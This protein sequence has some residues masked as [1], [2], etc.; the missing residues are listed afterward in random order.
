[1]ARRS[2]R[3]PRAADKDQVAEPAEAQA[4]AGP[5]TAAPAAAEGTATPGTVQDNTSAD[6]GGA[7]GTDTQGAENEAAKAAAGPAAAPADKAQEQPGG[8]DD[9]T[10]GAPAGD[11]DQAAAMS[12]T[13][14]SATI[15]M[16]PIGQTP[17][18]PEGRG[19]SSGMVVRVTGPKKGRWRIGRR[20]DRTPVDIP[21]DDLSEGDRKALDA[22]KTLTIEVVPAT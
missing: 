3:K 5:D 17:T 4:P 10:A 11:E 6:T 20:F 1:M 22:D 19:S 15:S 8:G 18:P 21:L 14:T 7:A 13:V 9:G 2:T 16:A 12:A